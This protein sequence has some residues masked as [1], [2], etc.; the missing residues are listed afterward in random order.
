MVTQNVLC[1]AAEQDNDL[2][3]SFLF[4]GFTF[5]FFYGYINSYDIKS[6]I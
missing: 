5:F 6:V 3:I 1:Q 2:G 4:P